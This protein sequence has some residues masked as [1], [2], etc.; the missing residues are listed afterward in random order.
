MENPKIDGGMILESVSDGVFTVDRNLNISSFNQAAEQITGLSKAEAVGRQC[1]N[2]FHS[3]KC[4]Q[5]C[6]L[7][8][9]IG[10][11][12]PLNDSSIVITV[13]QEK[14]IPI[15]ISTA[16]LKNDN[17]EIIG[18]I[19]IF[20][21]L[22]LV[23]TMEHQ[24]CD[25]FQIGDM[26][27]RNQTMQKLFALVPK[28]GESSC[29]VLIEGETGTGKELLARAIHNTSPRKT[30]PFIAI[31]CGALPDTLLES[32]L[33]G[34][35]AGAFTDATKD[36]PGHFL[37][38]EGG[39][40]FLDEIGETSSAFQTRLL[41]VLEQR[42]IVPLGGVTS[43]QVD[44]RVIVATNKS[45]YDLVDKGDFRQDLYYRIDVMQLKLPPLRERKEDIPLLIEYFIERKNKRQQKK[46]K[47]IDKEILP[48]FLAYDYPGNVRELENLIERAYIL[49]NNGIIHY[50][51]LPDILKHGPEK[52]QNSHLL[53]S[54]A[55]TSEHQA[56]MEALLNNNSRTD[57]ARELGIHKSTLFRKIKKLGI[58][59][60]ASHKKS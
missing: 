55:V 32:E 27:S 31:N 18:C 22:R 26:V 15:D 23:D 49:C 6:I 54:A 47:G 43:K 20:R 29:T 37:L 52:Q 51:H 10:L 44:V 35:K 2:V 11:G 42:Q 5:D 53:E 45:L 19:G 28:I 38:A 56:I 34:Y 16:P 50:D 9:T 48:H 25:C 21:D 39:T 14:Q 30:K 24:L 59:V 57:A 41:R 12:R 4:N 58:T 36:K 46:I 60:P 13:K 7:K 33:F 17:E 8:N 1:R 40:I 3:N